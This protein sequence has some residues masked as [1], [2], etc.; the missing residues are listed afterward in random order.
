MNVN[1]NVFQ[2]PTLKT[3]THT[4]FSKIVCLIVI[5]FLENDYTKE[6]MKLVNETQKILGT[7][8]IGIT[9]TAVRVPVHGGHSESV[10]VEFVKPFEIFEV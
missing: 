8:A 2:I 4:P 6:E 9:A 7:T 10:N 1:D 5:F 3:L